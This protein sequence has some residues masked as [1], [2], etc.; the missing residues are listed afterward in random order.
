MAFDPRQEDCLRLVLSAMKRDRIYPLND[1]AYIE[2]TMLAYQND[3]TSLIKTDRDRSFHLVCL[4]TELI[5]YQM[6]FLTS[7]DEINKLIERVERY[8]TEAVRID[9]HNWDA[10]RMLFTVQSQSDDELVTYLLDNRSDVAA[11]AKR[12]I[13]EADD[14]YAREF[15]NDLGQH[16]YQ[17]WLAS[18]ASRQFIAGQYRCALATVEECLAIA[19]LDWAGARHTG[20][21]ALA[22]LE[23]DRAELQEF[24][25]R[26]A[27][28]Y[29]GLVPFAASQPNAQAGSQP[30]DPWSLI[31]EMSLAYRAFDYEGATETLREILRLFP[32]APQTLFVQAEFPEGM[33][34]RAHIMPGS[35]DEL[36]VALSEATPL[37]QEGMGTPD[38]ASFALWIAEHELVQA[39]LSEQDLQMLE[40]M[41]GMATGGGA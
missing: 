20:M 16:P 28:A 12:L 32:H 7:E 22:K 37:L 13:D 27:L 34:S 30:L 6:P 33:F 31:A 5:D 41:G 2:R 39:G 26:H 4:A 29:Q 25:T 11:E 1:A 40:Q 15:A 36:V 17:R 9:E 10:K 35:D 24:R 21:L 14:P 19:P 3:P 8:L 38:S 18:L 23:V